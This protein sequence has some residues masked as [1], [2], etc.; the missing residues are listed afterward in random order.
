MRRRLVAA[1]GTDVKVPNTAVFDVSV[2][3]AL[4]RARDR[5]R[6]SVRG[7]A[8][9]AEVHD[10]LDGFTDASL[11]QHC[12]EHQEQDEHT[13]DHPLTLDRREPVSSDRNERRGGRGSDRLDSSRG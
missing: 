3:V 2:R 1:T 10:V 12:A 6:L 11:C 4:S 8:V 7:M 9:G 5:T 13:L